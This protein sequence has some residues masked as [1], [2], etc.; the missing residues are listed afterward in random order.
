MMMMMMIMLGIWSMPSK[1]MLRRD[2]HEAALVNH[3]V[4]VVCRHIGATRTPALHACVGGNTD[5]GVNSLDLVERKRDLKL[6]HTGTLAQR[7]ES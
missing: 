4:I 6:G 2:Q 3:M 5:R 7:R 1:L